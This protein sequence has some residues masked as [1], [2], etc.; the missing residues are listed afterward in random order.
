VTLDSEHEVFVWVANNLEDGIYIVS[1][2]YR[3]QFM[4]KALVE[5]DGRPGGQD[6][7]PSAVP[8]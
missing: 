2:D 4:N 1:D 5:I 6:L 8:P 3:I 7:L